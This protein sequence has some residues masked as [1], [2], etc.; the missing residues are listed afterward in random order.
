MTDAAARIAEM[1][2]RL[3]HLEEANRLKQ[4]LS[5][6][7]E[8]PKELFRQVTHIALHI[9]YDLQDKL[10]FWEKETLELS[11]DEV[12]QRLPHMAT[13]LD[14]LQQAYNDFAEVDL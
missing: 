1:E 12:A 4:E 14:Q 8:D 5:G 10:R 2:D 7:P 9:S 6:E 13:F 11:D 3:E